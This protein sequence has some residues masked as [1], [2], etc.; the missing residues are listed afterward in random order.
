[1]NKL[2]SFKII[3]LLG[4]LLIMM[5]SCTEPS[6][7]NGAGGGTSSAFRLQVTVKDSSGKS[8]HGVRVSAYNYL[9]PPDLM[10]QFG[11]NSARKI[12]SSAMITYAL[13]DTYRVSLSVN[14]LDGRTISLPVQSR[15]SLPGMYA[16]TLS[17]NNSFAGTRVYKAVLSA[18]DTA[19]R[20]ERFRDSIYIT[21]WQPD[22]EFSVV[23]YTSEKGVCESNDS[24]L[25]PHLLQLPAMTRTNATG[26]DSVGTFTFPDIYVITL[27]DTL[28]KQSQSFVRTVGKGTND[29][30]LTWN[31]SGIGISS[32]QWY[33]GNRYFIAADS[34]L[35]SRVPTVTKLFQNYP[36][37]FN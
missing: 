32:V 4:A 8:L 21:L 25:F 29:I 31:S 23:G 15:M 37:P 12:S 1:M 14:E 6:S 9:F 36:N 20:T 2:P 16:V 30:Q 22:A 28:T 33:S 26:P 5:N 17:V 19:A 34:T 35:P 18:V 24:L 10:K 7:D 27:T 3:F 13:A 11:S